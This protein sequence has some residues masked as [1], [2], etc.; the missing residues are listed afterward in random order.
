[1]RLTG[2][3]LTQTERVEIRCLYRERA[4]SVQAIADRYGVSRQTVCSVAKAKPRKQK[5]TPPSDKSEA[6]DPLEADRTNCL[7]DDTAS[8]TKTEKG[9]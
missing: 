7:S 5:K 1:M 9:I 3:R 6:H 2:R 8:T 4:I